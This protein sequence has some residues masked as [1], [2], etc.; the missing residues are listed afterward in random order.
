MDVE[1]RAAEAAVVA[2]DWRGR[3]CRP[4]R[5]GGMRAAVFVLGT[6]PRPCIARRTKQ[7]ASERLTELL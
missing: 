1:S 2:V 6:R 3:P 5:H 4:H 7:L